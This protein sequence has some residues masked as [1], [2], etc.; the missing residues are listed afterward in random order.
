VSDAR[1]FREEMRVARH[2]L[3]GHVRLAVIPTA[4][5]WAAAL[6]ARFAEAHPGV[7]FTILSRTSIEILG[8]LENLDIEAGISYLDNEPLGRVV[9]VPIYRERYVLVCRADCDLAERARIGWAELD[10][11]RMCLLTPDMQ[12][13]RIINQNF[14][15]AGVTPEAQVE[16]NSTLVLVSH[17]RQGDWVTILPAE[18]AEV[19]ATGPD[20]AIRP[21]AGQ[22]AQHSV[23]LIAPHR[24]PHT[25]VL[26][27]LL[28]E[29]ASLGKQ[30]RKVAV[31]R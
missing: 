18:M 7:R 26:G 1:T 27:A 12:N 14:M 24:E 30:G 23:G 10:G 4:L 25:P 21:M 20:F 8:M 9:T 19:L 17:V 31:G 16:A 28:S 6:S 22:S 3:T 15:D 29:A 2:G 11:R 13:R 5:T